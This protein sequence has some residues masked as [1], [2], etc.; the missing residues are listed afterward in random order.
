VTPGQGPQS[1]LFGSVS[2]SWVAFALFGGIAILAGVATTR[3]LRRLAPPADALPYYGT[4]PIAR[5]TIG[6]VLASGVL[7]AIWW[8][9]WS[10]FYAL[11]VGRDSV[12]LEYHGP[13]RQHVV[14]KAEIAAIRWDTGPK[15]TRVLVVETR[16]GTS[17][18]SMQTSA[19]DAFER[20]VVQAV[21]AAAWTTP[22]H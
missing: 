17:Y 22:A 13:R 14:P 15:S 4:T 21:S 7:A 6:V 1:F 9:L 3:M 10:G 2:G 19:N 8:W 12:R 11:E 16:S 18:R 5:R 20:R